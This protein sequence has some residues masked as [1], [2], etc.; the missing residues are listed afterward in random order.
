MS[1]NWLLFLFVCSI[2]SVC[3]IIPILS[4]D[5]LRESVYESKPIQWFIKVWNRFWI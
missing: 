4:E 2:L 3:L 1:D 5:E